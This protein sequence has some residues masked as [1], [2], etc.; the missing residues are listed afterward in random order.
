MKEGHQ[1]KVALAY[2]ASVSVGFSACSRRFS[3]FGSAKIGVSTT[4]M[5][6]YFFAPAPIFVRSRSEICFKPAESP[7]ETLAMQAK[8]APV[9]PCTQS[10]QASWSVGGHRDWFWGTGIFTIEI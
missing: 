3:P 5:E 4:L 2:V 6:A 10:P 1:A 7:M 8:V 9:Q